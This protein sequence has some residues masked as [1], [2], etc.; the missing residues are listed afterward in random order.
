MV[1]QLPGLHQLASKMA[2]YLSSPAY[3]KM[4]NFLLLVKFW[5]GKRDLVMITE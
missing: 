3:K 5:L 2:Q 4:E 1:G